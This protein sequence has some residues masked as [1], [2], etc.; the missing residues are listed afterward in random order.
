MNAMKNNPPE[1]NRPQT[2]HRIS[3]RDVAGALGL[4]PATVS[5]ALRNLPGVSVAQRARIC[6]TAEAMGYAPDPL[7]SSLSSYRTQQHYGH[8]QSELAWINAWNQPKGLR[9]IREFDLYWD[10]ACD[11]AKRMGYRLE[12]FH[13]ATMTPDR[14]QTI[15]K[16]R[17]IQGILLPPVRSPAEGLDRF[18][19]SDFAIVRF[20]QTLPHPAAHFVSSAQMVNTMQ[21]FDRAHAL[22]YKRIGF[23]CEYWRMRFFSVGYSW[24]Q[25]NLTP[26][27]QLPLLTL[28]PD[29]NFEQQQQEFKAWL[30]ATTP[31]AILTDNSETHQMLLNLGYRVPED[32]GLA[33]TSIHDTSIDAGID[34]RPYEIGRA[35]IRTLTALIAEKSFGLPDCR[36]EIL[37]EGNWVD[38]SMLPERR[39]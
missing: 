8:I 29:D 11:T 30:Q 1:E 37:V 10:G 28:N 27:Q 2:G 14:L 34:Q 13:L 4:S 22:G 9:E 19:W 35:A 3:Q 33:T 16:T 17:H 25:K 21:A 6:E 39:A 38:G 32:I 24:A 18:D 15:L 36:N 5:K 7:L 26:S 23:V 20:G 12:E 31:D